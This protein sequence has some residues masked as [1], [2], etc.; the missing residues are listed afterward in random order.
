MAPLW[1][2][3]LPVIRVLPQRLLSKGWGWFARRELPQGLQ[4]PVNR[5]FARLFRVDLSE[6]EQPPEAYSSLSAFFVR[7]LREGV[8][9]WPN[10]DRALGSPADGVLGRSGALTEGVAL[11]AKGISYD[12][13]ELLGD[14]RDALS[15]QSGFFLTIYLSPRHYH[16]VH[17]PCAARFRRA[18][19]I[20]GR[21]LPVHP[22]TVVRVPRLFVG[23]ERLVALMETDTTELAVVAVGAFNVGSIS[24]D[25]DP[26]WGETAARGPAKETRT[27]G[28]TNRGR[29]SD[30]GE[31]SYDP[32]LS[33]SRGDPLMAFHLGS[34]VILLVSP[35][36]GSSVSLHPDLQEGTEIRVGFPLLTSPTS[37]AIRGREN[38]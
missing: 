24:P 3:L 31:R 15:F 38:P 9:K 13:G 16:R 11:Q 17:A 36:E 34:T 6:A 12:V 8:R 33:L 22:A 26:E 19:A 30:P 32:P 23:N 18:R 37:S 25:F 1:R 21:L 20:R 5:G 29:G 4:A 28:I 27:R 2:V 7:R 10:D 35:K 14:P